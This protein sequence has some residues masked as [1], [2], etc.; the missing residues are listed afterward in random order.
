MGFGR[1]EAGQRAV[2]ESKVEIFGGPRLEG[3]QQQK[4]SR[5]GREQAD[6]AVQDR[7][8][9]TDHAD[10]DLGQHLHLA[11]DQLEAPKIGFERV[12]GGVRVAD[13]QNVL[14]PWLQDQRRYVLRHVGALDR[15]IGGDGTEPSHQ[16]TIEVDLGGAGLAH[17]DPHRWTE[18]LGD[19]D[20]A[21]EPANPRP[22]SRNGVHVLQRWQNEV[23]GRIVEER[24][25]PG[26]IVPGVI[27]P[28]LDQGRR[29]PE[30]LF[31][32]NDGIAPA[33][34]NLCG[35]RPYGRQCERSQGWNERVS[36]PDRHELEDSPLEGTP[37][38][39]QGCI[40]DLGTESRPEPVSGRTIR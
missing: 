39:R 7:G 9:L 13:R 25:G 31:F 5:E 6:R 19:H 11:D 17:E 21:P 23:P 3:E 40:E 33:F 30:V 28:I 29:V 36:K 24:I 12:A 15:G 34:R 8:H 20:L 10:A 22:A 18:I 32:E 1:Q 26:G 2:E 16:I 35:S 14:D 4:E 27:P 37:S 38:G